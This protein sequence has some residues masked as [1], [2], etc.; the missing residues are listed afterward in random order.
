MSHYLYRISH[1]AYEI[2]GPY[3]F[4]L[5]INNKSAGCYYIFA[6]GTGILPFLDLFDFLLRKTMWIS[7]KKKFGVNVAKIIN[8]YE[9]DFDNILDN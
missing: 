8:A 5:Q 7:L 3:G 4:G 1:K 6:N 2:T 9:E